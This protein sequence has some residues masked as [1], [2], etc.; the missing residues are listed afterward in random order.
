MTTYDD[1]KKNSKALRE[2]DK[3]AI[4]DVIAWVTEAL[5]YQYPQNYRR[6][7]EIVRKNGMK[8]EPR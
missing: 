6:A 5:T 1:F 8:S 7:F 3:H 4:S 2:L